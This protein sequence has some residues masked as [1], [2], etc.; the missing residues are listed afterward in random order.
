VLIDQSRYVLQNHTLFLIAEQT[1]ADM[2]ALLS[3]FKPMVPHVVK[4]RAKELLNVITE[5]VKRGSSSG[6]DGSGTTNQKE[7]DG[8]EKADD[9]VMLDTE[10]L[11]LERESEKQDTASIWRGL[12]LLTPDP[13]RL[14]FA[15]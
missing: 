4:K 11:K 6:L 14:I 5:A 13:D 2:A 15:Q 9:V 3:L 10:V 8:S 1:P 12:L 7:A